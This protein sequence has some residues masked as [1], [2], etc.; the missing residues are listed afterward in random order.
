METLNKSLA[1]SQRNLDQ[2][3]QEL[4]EN[5]SKLSKIN[6]TDVHGKLQYTNAEIQSLAEVQGNLDAAEKEL[7]RAVSD[8][9]GKET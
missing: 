4:T 5:E 1:E 2:A 8:I 9:P 7:R 3:K 6:L